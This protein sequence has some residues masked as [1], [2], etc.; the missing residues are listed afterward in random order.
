MR[1]KSQRLS[2]SKI[3]SKFEKGK[4]SRKLIFSTTTYKGIH[5]PISSVSAFKNAVEAIKRNGVGPRERKAIEAAK[6]KAAA[7]LLRKNL[8]PNE[9]R[10]FRAILKMRTPRV[11][12][13]PP[14]RKTKSMWF[15]V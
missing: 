6:A 4:L 12:K 14:K 5:V 2:K 10:Q 1:R 9:R 13:R 3:K 8:S 15:S 11:N 7:Q